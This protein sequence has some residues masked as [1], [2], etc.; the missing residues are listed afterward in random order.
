MSR[1]IYGV[2]LL[3]SVS[4]TRNK[5]TA[6]VPEYTVCPETVRG[7]RR[8]TDDL[9]PVSPCVTCFFLTAPSGDLWQVLTHPYGRTEREQRL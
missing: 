7:L 4:P 3:C 9:F 8:L 5:D 2:W 1:D 6:E